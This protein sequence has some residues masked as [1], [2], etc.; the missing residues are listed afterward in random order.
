MIIIQQ[1]TVARE[2][3]G[4]Y[5]KHSWVELL[6]SINTYQEV[7][8]EMKTTQNLYSTTKEN[9]VN[10]FWFTLASITTRYIG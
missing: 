8:T 3:Q 6:T 4:K 7:V 2:S 5:P 9:M 10:L 1:S